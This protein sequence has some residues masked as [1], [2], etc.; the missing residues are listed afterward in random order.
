MRKRSTFTRCDV[1]GQETV[2][3]SEAGKI[4]TPPP[5]RMMLYNQ[6]EEEVS[7]RDE[8]EEMKMRQK[9]I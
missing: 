6:E 9:Q 8:E 1:L 4:R 3:H 2:T 7:I 5:K